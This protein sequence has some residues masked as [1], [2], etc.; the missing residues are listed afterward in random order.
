MN[1]DINKRTSQDLLNVTP[2][3][4]ENKFIIL[5]EKPQETFKTFRMQTSSLME[6]VQKFLPVINR[7]NEFLATLSA[8][9]K[10]ELNIENTINDTKVIEISL[11]IVD[12][13]LILSDDEYNEDSSDDNDEYNE[14][15]SHDDKCGDNNKS[16]VNKNDDQNSFFNKNNK[17]L[18]KIEIL[19]D[20]N[21]GE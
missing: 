11:S 10:A 9:E 2:D 19:N 14:D 16:N 5:K 15:S 21:E 13:K 6:K 18:K 12:D 17:H 8:E 1:K 3:H 7:D 4:I 20:E